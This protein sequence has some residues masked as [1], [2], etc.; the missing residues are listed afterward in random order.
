[1]N[2]GPSRNC[3]I[4]A[5]AS[6]WISGV[7]SFA[8]SSDTPCLLKGGG[9]VG[10]GCVGYSTSP[11]TSVVVST[12]RSSMGHTGSPVTRSNTY[13]KPCFD[14]CATASISRPS[15]VMVTRFGAAARS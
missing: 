13:V 6:A 7:R 3:C 4:S 15:T 12:A 2:S 1:M 9:L 5:S 10:N 11:G 14:T 8:S